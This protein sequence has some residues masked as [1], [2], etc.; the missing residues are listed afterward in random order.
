M[1]SDI[2]LRKSLLPHLFLLLRL[3]AEESPVLREQCA[4]LNLFSEFLKS[5][6]LLQVQQLN[7]ARQAFGVWA[8]LQSSGRIVPECLGAAIS[9]LSR[10][11]HL[12]LFIR[13]QNAG[14]LISSPTLGTDQTNT[15]EEQVAGSKLHTRGFRRLFSG[16][17][18]TLANRVKSAN[19]TAVISTFPLSLPTHQ[20]VSSVAAPTFIYPATS[21]S[22]PFSSLLKSNF[23]AEE[24]S[25][26]DE[27]K[28]TSSAVRVVRQNKF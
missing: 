10:G 2:E 17:A 14:L 19:L 21:V 28:L 18:A 27:I 6:E 3:P 12:P 1:S 13:E 11:G 15:S 25:R 5:P 20:V 22:V 4:L 23:L 24:I 7:V 8:D 16:V 9:G 26:L